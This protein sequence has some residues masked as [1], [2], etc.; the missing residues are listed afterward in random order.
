M[1][2]PHHDDL[3]KELIT[4]KERL[5]GY[6]EEDA[7]LV[8]ADLRYQN[9]AEIVEKV[10]TRQRLIQPL[11]FSDLLDEVLTHR[12]LG[13]PIFL[14]ILWVTFQLTFTVA[15]PFM[16][17]IDT[18]FGESATWVDENLGSNENKLQ[19]ALASL[20]AGG[21][22]AGVGGV[23]IFVPQIFVLFLA[24]A[25]LEQSGYLARAA[26]VMDK[27]MT[28]IGLH[29]QS[30][31]P[32]LLGFGCNIPGIMATR[33]I[34][35]EKDRLVTI[36]VNPFMSCSARL[37]VYI[38]FAGV[39]FP[40]NQATVVMSLYLLGMLVAIGV[41]LSL[42]Q[43]LFK[44]PP[45]P[46]IME[47]PPY[48]RPTLPS[49]LLQMWDRG[50]LFIRKA[51]T[52]ILTASIFIWGLANVPYD[53]QIEDTAIGLLGKTLEPFFSPMGWDWRLVAALFFGFIAKEVVV[54]ALAVIYTS[55]EEDEEGLKTALKAS[56]AISP[57]QAYAY[58]VFVLLYV[59]CVA[60]L[61]AIRG[62][63]KSWTWTGFSAAMATI[64]AYLVALT[65]ILG[66]TLLGLD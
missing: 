43:T 15:A 19:A 51:G 12:W 16:D 34:K 14:A 35:G 24:L 9:I 33:S 18:I 1:S 66:G 63:T 60:A 56:G 32:M 3:R 64:I 21:I 13:I 20:L 61:G 22:I 38:L 65:I 40:N 58:M 7:D 10:V 28:R 44:G 2:S 8:M 31:V 17:L 6:F 49:T 62:E 25:I 57:L 48:L 36:L 30:M 52:I 50:K 4:G 53:E 23:L 11:T 46:F 37:P 45:S 5:R 41:A 55:E 39:F 59:P 54:A 27:L 42:R 29:G 26:F 47:L